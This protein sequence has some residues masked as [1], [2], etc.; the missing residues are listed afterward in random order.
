MDRT[1]LEAYYDDTKHALDE[2]IKA[3]K[4]LV[5]HAKSLSDA[6]QQLEN[7]TDASTEVKSAIDSALSN[8]YVSIDTLTDRVAELFDNYQKLSKELFPKK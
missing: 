7:S 6:V 8:L 1:A 4:S 5:T 3:L 2:N